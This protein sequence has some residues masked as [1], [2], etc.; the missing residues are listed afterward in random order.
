LFKFPNLLRTPE[1]LRLPK[2]LKLM[3][4]KGS[5]VAL[6]HKGLEPKI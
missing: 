3:A 5:R 6:H 1:F 4:R 2:A